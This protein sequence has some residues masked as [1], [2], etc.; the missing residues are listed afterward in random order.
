M[1]DKNLLNKKSSK[2]WLV[3][4]NLRVEEGAKI[5]GL[6]RVLRKSKSA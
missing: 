5:K 1:E 6:S 4:A 2:I 3:N